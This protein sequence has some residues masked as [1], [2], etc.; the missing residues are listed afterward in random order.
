MGETNTPQVI[1]YG[2]GDDPEINLDAEEVRVLGVLIEKQITTP[3]VYP[4]SLNSLVNGCNQISSRDPVVRYDESTVLRALDRLRDAK[5]AFVYSGADSRTLKYGHKI[6]DRFEFGPAEIAALCVLMLRGPQTTGEIRTRSGRLHEF[7]S[8]SDVEAALNTLC[9][10]QPKPLAARLP[11]QSG[12]KESRYGH[13]LSGMPVMSNDGRESANEVSE[14]SAVSPSV[15]R[16]AQLEREVEGLQKEL[17]DLR[18]Q[19]GEFRRQF[20]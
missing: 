14:V 15:D 6:R 16:V 4:L 2:S 7:A 18:Q 19:F 17:A 13:L 5:L 20:E 10:L 8:L 9:T 1:V 3:D 11:R 12:T